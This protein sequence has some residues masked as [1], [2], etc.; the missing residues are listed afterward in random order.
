M[1]KAD[2]SLVGKRIRVV[3]MPEEPNPLVDG[4]GTVLWVHNVTRTWIQIGVRWEGMDE[5]RVLAL[6]VPPDTYEVLPQ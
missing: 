2:Q 1:P 3:S 6:A 5:G 4:V